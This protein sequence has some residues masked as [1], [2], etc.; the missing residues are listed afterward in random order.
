M[1]ILFVHGWSVRHTD[2]YGD[3]PR[4]LAAQTDADGR[5]FEVENV[6][7]GKYISFDDTVAMDDI[8]R[9]LGQA[10][11]RQLGP[12]L[13]AGERFAAITHSTG[14]PVVRAW[15]DLFWK[16]RLAQCPLSHLVMLA[17]ANHGSALAQLGKSRLSRIKSLFQGVDPGQ[18][19]LD[20][21]ELGSAESWALNR[22]W[23]NYDCV[24]E[25]V[26]PFVLTGQSIDRKLYD[27]LN[28]YTGEAGS[29]GVVRVAA[30]NLN[31]GL[32][33][34]VQEGGQLR[35]QRFQRAAPT[36]MGVL[37]GLSHSGKEMGILRS[38]SLDGAAEHPTAEWVL[39]CLRVR[40]ATE[41]QQLA[42][43]LA[44]LTDSTQQA[45]RE[46]QVRTLLGTRTYTNPRHTMMVFRLLD[47]RGASLA[48]YDLYF[49]AGPRYDENQLPAGF[50]RDRQRNQR[51]RGKLTY[52]L[53][54]DTMAEGLAHPKLGGRLG[55]YIEARP[56]EEPRKPKLVFYRPLEFQGTLS[57][58]NEL[59]HPNETLMVEI[60]LERLVDA[61]VFQIEKGLEPSPISAKPSH[62]LVPANGQE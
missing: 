60:Q 7:L 17:P 25:G 13:R 48:D 2:T 3:L 30:A 15:M 56:A 1:I 28:S 5:P 47:D 20:W 41:Y 36:A 43:N 33:R 38:V 53:N 61:A 32:L 8:A 31:Y 19:V 45:E 54:H 23:L 16:G 29:D 59:L 6:F 50:F 35:V 9:A 57:Q 44:T 55:F 18:R 62:E 51:D 21:L 40:H 24:A 37:P 27:A 58:L 10:L 42:A 34:L 26:F 52:Y 39:R 22:S 49:T 46:E 14:G 12:R 4:W 11:E